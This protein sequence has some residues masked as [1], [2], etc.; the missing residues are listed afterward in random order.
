[1]RKAYSAGIKR[2]YDSH[3]WRKVSKLFLRQNPLCISC[4]SAGIDTPA[5]IVHHNPPHNNDPERFWDEN[6][7]EAVCATCHSGVKNIE[8]NHG[9]SQAADINGMPLD[10]GHPWNKQ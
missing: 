5:T 6:T 9:Y 2:L 10:K 7:F 4:K 3:R 1:M 8:E